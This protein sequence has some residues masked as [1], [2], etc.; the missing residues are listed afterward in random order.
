[1]A[2]AGSIRGAI[3]FGLAMSIQTSSFENDQV[4]ISTSLILVFFTTII[5]GALMPSVIKHY[6]VLDYDILKGSKKESSYKLLSEEQNENYFVEKETLMF[7]Y[8]H[9]NNRYEY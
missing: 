1:M 7:S 5:F 3:A 4:L 9:P 2:F 8:S 6:K